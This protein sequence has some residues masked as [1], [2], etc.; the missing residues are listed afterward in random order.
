MRS[1]AKWMLCGYCSN[2]GRAPLNRMP[3]IRKL[4]AAPTG[5]WQDYPSGEEESLCAAVCDRWGSDLGATI[6]RNPSGETRY[7]RQLREQGG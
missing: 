5:A 2:P 1:Y 7:R 3:E 4:R 6:D